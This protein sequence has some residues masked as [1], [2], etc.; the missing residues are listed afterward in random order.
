MAF[1]FFDLASGL[2]ILHPL[3]NI[4]GLLLDIGGLTC[5]EL[6]L[7]LRHHVVGTLLNEGGSEGGT[8]SL[9]LL[10]L[11]LLELELAVP[12]GEVGGLPRNVDFLVLDHLLIE[13]ASE[14]GALLLNLL[15]VGEV[16]SPLVLHLLANNFVPLG[17]GHAYALV[18]SHSHDN[19]WN[20]VIETLARGSRLREHVL[21]AQG[22]ALAVD[23]GG[24]G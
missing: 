5:L 17:I 13:F 23:A 2:L 14:L 19:F 9:L 10:D 16:R 12:L 24:P 11:P 8:T 4:K 6:M 21:G 1:L 20:V 15:F 3:L 22:A 7:N 18:D